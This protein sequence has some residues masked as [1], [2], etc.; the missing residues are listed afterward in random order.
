MRE[1]GVKRRLTNL[2]ERFAEQALTSIDDEISFHQIKN[3]IHPGGHSPVIAR[4]RALLILSRVKLVAAVFAVL[5]PLWIVVDMMLFEWPL[6]GELALLRLGATVTFGLLAFD[7]KGSDSIWSAW[8][9]LIWLLAVPTLFFILSHPMVNQF[10]P[11]SPAAG[12]AAGYAF[13]PFVMV[14]GLSVFPLTT[15]ESI[16]F[17][18]PLVA[19]HL[20]AGV[21]GSAIFPFNSYLGALWLLLLLAVV[22]TLAAMSQLHFMTALV[23]QS[24]HDKLTGVLAR[25]VGEEIL[26]L[27]FNHAVR[28]LRPLSLVFVDLDHFKMVN[29]RYGHEE[30]DRVLRTAAECL[31]KT[32]RQTDI[33]VRWGGEE[34]L[35]IMPETDGP[36]AVSALRRLRAVGLGLRPDGTRQT[37]SIGVAECLSDGLATYGDLIELADQRMYQ[38]KQSG[39][40]RVYTAEGYVPM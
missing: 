22:A 38:A 9:A 29:D 12:I 32:L 28:T 27:Q 15:A 23:E 35:V 18:L 31:Q 24:A 11:N 7:Y 13:L 39:R 5:T 30:G 26:N 19:S 6:W 10:D 25:R 16:A 36:G 3:L 37:A 40:D 33:V 20:V 2:I 14:A 17:S 8:K 1:M 4:R 21:F 34:F